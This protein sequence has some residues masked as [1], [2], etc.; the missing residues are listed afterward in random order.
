[1]LKHVSYYFSVGM[2]ALDF[3]LDKENS[4]NARISETSDKNEMMF[5]SQKQLDKLKPQSI[6]VNNIARVL[7]VI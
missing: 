6:S 7:R 3:E 1:M 2:K 5:N 4:E